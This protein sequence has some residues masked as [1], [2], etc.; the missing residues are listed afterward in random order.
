EH[1]WEYLEH[2]VHS[3]TPLPWNLS[4]LWDALLE[5]WGQ[6]EDTYIVKLYESMPEHVQALLEAKGMHT[7]Y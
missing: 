6:I 2:C 3:C 5:E 4:A 7:R 1:V